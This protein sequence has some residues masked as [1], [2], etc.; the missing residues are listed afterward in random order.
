MILIPQYRTARRAAAANTLKQLFDGGAYGFWYDYGNDALVW[1]DSAR[2]TPA[3]NGDPIGGVTDKSP[4][5]LHA[6]Q[7][8]SGDRPTRSGGAAVGDGVSDY[9]T[10]TVSLST[11]KAFLFA[12]ITTPASIAADKGVVSYY[13]PGALDYNTAA[14]GIPAYYS[15]STSITAFRTTFMGSRTVAASTK[16]LLCSIYDGT[17]NKMSL[18]GGAESSASSTGTFSFTRVSQCARHGAGGVAAINGWSATKIHEVALVTGVA[19][20]SGDVALVISEMMA[21]NGI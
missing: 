19:I 11:N 20:S 1:Q 18:N 13:T 4:N 16:Y 9:L 2:S 14:N 15:G 3:A 7:S 21:R 10:T 17:S 12:V 6:A 5:G 8:T